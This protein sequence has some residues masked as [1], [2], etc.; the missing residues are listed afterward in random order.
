MTNPLHGIDLRE[1]ILEYMF[2]LLGGI[3]SIGSCWR[4]RGP[5]PE[6]DPDSQQPL[7]PAIIL[8]D[9][10]TRLQVGSETIYGYKSRKMPPV[11]VIMSPEIYVILDKAG[12]ATNT[13]DKNGNP[14]NPGQQL[15]FFHWQI[16]LAVENE[17]GLMALLTP[18]GQIV[19]TGFETDM[20]SGSAVG[21]MGP[22]GCV[23]YDLYFP[24][25]PPRS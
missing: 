9:G 18:N 24:M 16:K 19:W 17:P 13:T 2:G 1:D 15:S 10:D 4:N 23:S 14:Y 5:V 8:L 25:Q 3:P 20:K 7:R 21:A 12:D 6:L 11:P 22:M